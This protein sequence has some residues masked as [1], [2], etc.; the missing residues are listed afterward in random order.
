MVRDAN[1]CLYLKHPFKVRYIEDMLHRAM[2]DRHE[3]RENLLRASVPEHYPLAE[4][5][6]ME[7]GK[8]RERRAA[9]A[10]AAVAG[11]ASPA[12]VVSDIVMGHAP[13]FG[14]GDWGESCNK[15]TKH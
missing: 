2:S 8:R 7:T 12:S 11:T 13:R 10:A 6:S 4:S 1:Y 14:D 15:K 3:N 9:A 5:S